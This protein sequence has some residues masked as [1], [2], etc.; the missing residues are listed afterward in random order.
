MRFPKQNELKNDWQREWAWGDDFRHHFNNNRKKA[1]VFG[2]FLRFNKIIE[3]VQKLLPTLQGKTILDMGAAHC[4]FALTLAEMGYKVTAIDI[5]QD[6]LD[7][8]KLKHQN[9][10][11]EYVKASF[12]DY[13]G[14]PNFYDC[15]I[16]GEI[17]EHVAM[18]KELLSNANKNLKTGGYLVLST[19]NGNEF[20]STYKTYSQIDDISKYIP[21]Q[22]HWVGHTFLYT[23]EELTK[24]GQECGFETVSSETINCQA[25]SQLKALRYILPLKIL[26]F[27]ETK[28]KYRKKEGKDTTN[29]IVHCYKK[30]KNL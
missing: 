22:F 4:N 11:I 23:Q 29:N 5:Q 16:C 10:D 24:L 27:L 30:T 9:G 25:V 13:C 6:F 7:Y 26:Y 1:S 3:N 18:P 14:R 20:G 15:V 12:M 8:A 2:Y 17:I 28:L 21:K 19:P